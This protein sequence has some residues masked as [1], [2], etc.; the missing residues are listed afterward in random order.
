MEDYFNNLINKDIRVKMKNEEEDDDGNLKWG[1]IGD[2][3]QPHPLNLRITSVEP[4]QGGIILLNTTKGEVIVESESNNY[5]VVFADWDAGLGTYGGLGNPILCDFELSANATKAGGRKK[6]KTKRK[7]RRKRRTRKQMNKIRMKNPKSCCVGPG[8]PE[9]KHCINVLGDKS[10]G[11]RPKTENTL[12]IIKKCAQRYS[13]YKN[14]N[15]KKCLKRERKKLRK[16]NKKKK[17]KKYRV[18]SRK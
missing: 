10:M 17:T 8:C 1:K 4:Q 14:K 18:K 7:K 15:Y 6:R 12:K 13:T 16:K 11:I 5:S 3:L 9:W 2:V